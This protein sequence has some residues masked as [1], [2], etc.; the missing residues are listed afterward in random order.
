MVQWLARPSSGFGLGNGKI[1]KKE[2]HGL[3][4]KLLNKSFNGAIV[5]S[6]VSSLEDIEVKNVL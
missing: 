2:L 6:E 3:A 5:E 4:V 1:H